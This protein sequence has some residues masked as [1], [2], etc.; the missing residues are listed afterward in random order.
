M[1]SHTALTIAVLAVTGCSNDSVI[2]EAG[3]PL[4][5][6]TP[7]AL[8][9][10]IVFG[11]FAFS[12]GEYNGHVRPD[13]LYTGGAV[14]DKGVN[15]VRNQLE[16]AQDSGL[17][18]WYN[19]TTADEAF[20]FVS[21]TNHDFSLAKWKA[22]FDRNVCP[23]GCP[24]DT[25]EVSLRQYINDGT[26]KGTW[27]LDDLAAFTNGTPTYSNLEAMGALAKRRFPGIA[28]AVRQRP[29]ELEN[30]TGVGTG[31][32]KFVN[33]DAAWGQYNSRMVP[34]GQYVSE[35][36]AAASRH[37]LKMVYGINVSNGGDNNGA[38][39][40]QAQLR[41]WGTPMLTN[42]STCSFIMWNNTYTL[43]N[44]AAMDSLS[45]L[46]KQHATRSCQ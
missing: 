43:Q 38:E 32:K 27:L 14:T 33:L 4:R 10:G 6:H 28:T 23:T 21:S 42:S 41:A 3:A 34:I 5:P 29:R 36:N 39:V 12:P 46:A 20:Y 31:T 18:W 40:T 45:K 22:E 7:S 15:H 44:T 24:N 25:S 35:Q 8:A 16:I 26:L 9:S 37:G 1:R 2:T 11:M 19:F 17:A 30:L 13:S